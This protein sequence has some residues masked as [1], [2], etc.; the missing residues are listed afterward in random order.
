[1]S[2]YSLRWKNNLHSIIRYKE[3]RVYQ[4]KRRVKYEK[5]YMVGT[6]LST[7][8]SQAVLVKV[9][10]NF[11]RWVYCIESQ[12]E[13]NHIMM[14]IKRQTHKKKRRSAW[15]EAASLSVN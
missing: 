6:N 15:N 10:I 5:D 11:I 14:P 13:L 1:M 12:E 8:K 7:M 4:D 3:H 2:I 9:G